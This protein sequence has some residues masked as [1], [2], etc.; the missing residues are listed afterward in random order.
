MKAKAYLPAVF[1]CAMCLP[2][3]AQVEVAPPEQ[4][5]AWLN[6]FQSL[7]RTNSAWSSHATRMK[8]GTDRQKANAYRVAADAEAGKQT[9][10]F[11]H[12]TVPAMSEMQY[13]PDAYPADGV[14][15]A[16]VRIFA[17]RNEYEPGS[18]VIYPFAQLGKLAFEV[19]DLTSAEG[20]V[21]PKS[22]LDL[23]TVK[24]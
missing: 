23:K 24:V 2:L 19:G 21:F 5:A 15:N 20:H 7:T 18:F 16:P 13:L 10:S 11:V 4:M 1:A 9:G 3:P 14:F 17:A 22:E 6:H 8:S 12:Y